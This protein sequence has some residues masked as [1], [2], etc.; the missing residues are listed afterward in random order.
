MQKSTVVDKYI[1]RLFFQSKKIGLSKN[2]FCNLSVSHPRL[3]IFS[4]TSPRKPK[5]VVQN[6]LGCGSR[7][8]ILSIHEKLS[9]K[10]SCYGPFN[11]SVSRKL[12]PRLL[13]IVGNISL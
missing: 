4:C 13:Y 8:S 10:I 12:R 11:G 1:Y 3:K 2:H 9:L 5:Y 6:I 7:E